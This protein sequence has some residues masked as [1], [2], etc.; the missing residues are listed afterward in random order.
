MKDKSILLGVMDKM[1]LF[2]GGQSL[3]IPIIVTKNS[4]T[5]VLPTDA[6]EQRP[7]STLRLRESIM[8]SKHTNTTHK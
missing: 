7:K 5:F 1:R 6:M 8:L 3:V 2:F 4:N